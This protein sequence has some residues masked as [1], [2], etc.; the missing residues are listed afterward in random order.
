MDRIVLLLKDIRNNA[1][2]IDVL[3]E[4]NGTNTS[5]KAKEILGWSYML[6]EEINSKLESN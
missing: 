1:K 6:E 2:D 5:S 4:G 3:N